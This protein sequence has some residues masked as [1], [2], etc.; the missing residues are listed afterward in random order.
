MEKK[1]RKKEDKDKEKVRSMSKRRGVR[2]EW[3]EREE[4]GLRGYTPFSSSQGPL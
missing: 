1:R 3:S 4:E 2:E